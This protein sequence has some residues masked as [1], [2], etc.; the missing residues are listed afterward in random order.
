[1]AQG[2]AEEIIAPDEEAVTAEFIAFLKAATATGSA[3][4]AVRA[5]QPGSRNGLRRLP[6]SRCPTACPPD[7]ASAVCDAAHLPLLD[8]VRQCR[9]NQSIASATFAA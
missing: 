9:L 8:P 2:L 7:R 3:A 4:G 1:M 6:S 5:V